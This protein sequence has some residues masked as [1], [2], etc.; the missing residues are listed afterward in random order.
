MNKN[1]DPAA[2]ETARTTGIPAVD[3]STPCSSITVRFVDDLQT[4]RCWFEEKLANGQWVMIQKTKMACEGN[5]RY[6]LAEVI[7]QRRQQ[8]MM[9]FRNVGAEEVI[10]IG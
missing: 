3:P 4:G 2:A 5:S 6:A 7:E 8:R 1:T 9:V 10:P